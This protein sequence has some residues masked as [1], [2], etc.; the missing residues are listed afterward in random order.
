MRKYFIKNLIVIKQSLKLIIAFA[1]LA[2]HTNC[3]DTIKKN[4][5]EF[6]QSK[7]IRGS[8]QRNTDLRFN[9]Y[10]DSLKVFKNVENVFNNLRDL[11]TVL[12]FD[13][14][15]KYIL[16][17]IEETEISN[18]ENWYFIELLGWEGSNDTITTGAFLANPINNLGYLNIDSVIITFAS[19]ADTNDFVE[20]GLSFDISNP[21]EFSQNFKNYFCGNC[22]NS[23]KINL[24]TRCGASVSFD[25]YHLFIFTML[26]RTLVGEIIKGFFIDVAL[27]IAKRMISYAKNP[28]LINLIYQL[29]KSIKDS[30]EIVEDNLLDLNN[31]NEIFLNNCIMS[32]YLYFKADCKFKRCF[33]DYPD[34]CTECYNDYYKREQA[35]EKVDLNCEYFAEY[36]QSLY[37]NKNFHFSNN[38]CSDLMNYYEQNRE[39]C[40]LSLLDSDEDLIPNEYDNCPDVSNSDQADWNMNGIG[41]ACEDLDNDG[42]IDLEDNC[43]NVSNPYQDDV[44]NDG[45]GDE[46]DNCSSFPNTNQFDMD[47]D[48]EGDECDNDTDGD[49]IDNVNDNCADYYNPYQE[50][51]D[52]DGEGDACQL[53]SCNTQNAID[54]VSA[55]HTCLAPVCN[56]LDQKREESSEEI[57]FCKQTLIESTDP[58]V[59]NFYIYNRSA[60]I[61]N[62]IMVFPGQIEVL[63][64]VLYDDE[65]L[66]FD[67]ATQQYVLTEEQLDSIYACL[68]YNI[69]EGALAEGYDPAMPLPNIDSYDQFLND[70]C[71]C[72]GD[73]SEDLNDIELTAGIEAMQCFTA[74]ALNCSQN[75][76]CIDK[77]EANQLIN[78]GMRPND[79]GCN[80]WPSLIEYYP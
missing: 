59:L 7:P 41:D 55:M 47:G 13:S 27:S 14:V 52:G 77:S 67:E 42:V 6:E 36:F 45:I 63:G 40:D 5:N 9:Y 44:D 28:T 75:K 78:N 46:C 74:T 21:V 1:L 4:I 62:G 8:F 24:E 49:G 35:C 58:F 71:V 10:S 60:T 57:E 69:L 54:Q 65:D 15:S 11:N 26:K 17:D 53:D 48:G 33:E 73:F 39:Y 2:I 31:I 43:I 20:F 68:E 3:E 76:P 56:A 12:F 37:Y 61:N 70:L 25:A 18:K 64:C 29:L 66:Y 79:M 34:D 23:Q 16:G 80:Y 51:S 30:G 50:D 72:K 32:D 19:I 22:N 38:D